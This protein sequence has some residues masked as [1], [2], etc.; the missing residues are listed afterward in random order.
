MFGP[1]KMLGRVLVLGRIAAADVPAFQ[2]KPQM[3]PCVA[4]LDAV[5]TDMLVRVGN[6]DLVH[7]IA[8]FCHTVSFTAGFYR[9][10]R[11]G[12]GTSDHRVIGKPE[13][14]KF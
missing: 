1:V 7:M 2:A 14:I 4:G 5:F 12:I 13:A 3:D 9:K 11:E 8:A 6:L 10:G